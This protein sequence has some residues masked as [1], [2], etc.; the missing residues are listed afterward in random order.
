MLTNVVS[1]GNSKG[2]RLPAALLRQCNIRDEVELVAGEDEIIIRPVFRQA[3]SG[4][5]EAFAAM[6]ARGEDLLLMEEDL[7]SQEWEWR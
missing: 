1:I 3:R 6:H 2:I 4:W 5:D 7:D